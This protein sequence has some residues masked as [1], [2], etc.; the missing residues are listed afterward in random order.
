LK[1]KGGMSKPVKVVLIVILAVVIVV[2]GGGFGYYCFITRS[3]LPQ[4]D[5]QLKVAGLKDRAEVIRDSHGVAYIYARNMH[6][7]FFAQGYVQAQDRW[8]QMEFYRKTCSGRIE[9]LTGKKPALV[10]TDIYLRTLGLYEATEKD[11]NS[12]TPEERATFDDFAEGVNAYI[13]GR[14][15]QQLSVNYAILGLTG[16]KFKIEPW[17]AIDSLAFTRLMALDLSLSRDLELIRAKLYDRLGAE[18]AEQ[19]VVPPWP[20]GQR[21]TILSDEDIKQT[22]GIDATAQP[23]EPDSVSL[24][25]RIPAIKPDITD[26]TP[27]SLLIREPN[28]GIGSN[29]WL[30]SGNMTA[31]GKPL[32]ANDIHLGILQPSIFYQVNLHCAD[33]GTGRP[34]NVGGFSFASFPGII[35]G[36]NNDIAWGVTSVMPDVNDYYQI[37]VSPANPLQYEWNGTWR[38]M[39][40]RDEVIIFGDGK[41]P[42]TVNVRLTH[43]GP[44][45]NENRFDAKTGEQS[46]YNNNDPLAVHW[47]GLEP[48]TIALSINKL[49]KARNWDEFRD[50]LKYWDTPSQDL[51]YADRQ[52]N[53]GLQ[54]PGKVPVRAS[55]HTGQ[56]P[57]PGWTDEYEWKG[58][59]P[60]ELMPRV[61]NPTRNYM[62]VCNQDIAPPQYFEMLNQK[63]G[64]GVNANFGSKYNKWFYGYRAQRAADLLNQLAPNTVLT[65]QTM[66]G[67]NLNI[68][69]Q[70]ILPSLAGLKFSTQELSDA[71]DWLLRWDY[72]C[73]ADSAQAALYNEL[74][75]RLMYNTFQAE[76]EGIA[77][78][79]AADREYY[80]INLLLKSPDDA[81]WDDPTTKDIKETRDDIL[82]KSFEE[83]YA[84]AAAAMGKDPNQW[85]WGRI[86][87]TIFVSNPLGAS[88]IGLIE[89]LVNQG[90]LSNSGTIE[91]LNNTV[92][93]A[94]NGNFNTKHGAAM[95][96]IVDLTDFDNSAGINSTGQSG[97]PGNPWYGDQNI[98]WAKMVY[99]PMLWSRQ[100]VDADT[101]HSLALN[102]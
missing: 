56:I 8:W 50:A 9:E 25:S 21:P 37:K 55:Y 41:P 17:T 39:T 94:S 22:Y 51:I 18:M 5:G 40:V 99:L 36:H 91:C 54:M 35:A 90:P 53:I 101:V 3:P 59:V 70:Q 23:S 14:S 58:Y 64:P 30:A 27:D 84:D 82:V 26:A 67:D 45:I 2:A 46:G 77:R 78:T 68:P 10:N 32:L 13:S 69:A 49:N 24:N 76:L 66:Q 48:S 97:H 60:Y 86:H 74:I 73:S 71:R 16:V 81:W 72:V 98:L 20:H 4:I 11:Y 31:S 62:S 88:S 52:G 92:W 96:M 43:L 75:M 38:D 89:A 42:V 12:F 61:Y 6:D 83:A 47:T 100:Q 1:N 87:K 28:E 95:R 15:P 63:L 19:W 102:P 93:Y 34:F 85:Q 79:D 44:I 29:S 57:V 65:F 7:L 80:A 33:D